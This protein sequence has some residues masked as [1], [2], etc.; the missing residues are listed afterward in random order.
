MGWRRAW[1]AISTPRWWSDQS[2]LADHLDVLTGEPHACLVGGGGEADRAG[3]ADPA[4]GHRLGAQVD[5]GVRFLN[6]DGSGPGRGKLEPFD[7]RHPPDRLVRA[8]VV[9]AVHPNIEL[10]LRILDRVEHLAVEELTAQRFVPALDAPMS[11]Q[12]VA[13]SAL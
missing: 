3:G 2:A 10:R 9:V 6:L 4:G 8:L 13:G 5:A 7:R 11:C 12:P 1:V